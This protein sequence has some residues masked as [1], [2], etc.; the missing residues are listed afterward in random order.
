VPACLCVGALADFGDLEFRAFANLGALATAG[1]DA[2]GPYPPFD[3]RHAGFSYGQ[4]SGCVVLETAEH[5]RARG[6]AA[7]AEIAGV[8]FL[9]DGHAASEPSAIGEAS[10]MRQALDHARASAAEVDYVNAHGTGTPAGDEAECEAIEAVFE[11]LAGPRVNST[12][13]LAGHTVYAAGIVELIATVVQMKGGFVHG[14]PGMAEPVSTRLRLVGGA[15]EPARI[16][17]ALSNS[18]SIGGINTCVAVRNLSA[19]AA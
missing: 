13:A 19:E 14:I 10:A 1:D 9:L 2:G 11:G 8:G 5:A 17:L 15:A 16:A 12:K 18:F 4:G 6:A 3:R 7:L